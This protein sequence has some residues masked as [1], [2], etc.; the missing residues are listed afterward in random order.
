MRAMLPHSWLKRN[1]EREAS[2]ALQRGQEPQSW[3]ECWIHRLHRSV[4]TIE[5]PLELV[6][7]QGKLYSLNLL[8]GAGSWHTMCM[9]T[10]NMV[11]MTWKCHYFLGPWKTYRNKQQPTIMFAILCEYLFHMT[12]KSK[13]SIFLWKP[14]QFRNGCREGRQMMKHR[15]YM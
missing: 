5:L 2:L 3:Y 11:S 9:L 8:W 12:S 4:I 10:M 6:L 1:R 7:W 15:F 13:R 14:I